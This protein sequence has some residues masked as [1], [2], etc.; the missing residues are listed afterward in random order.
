MISK[1]LIDN[2]KLY[3]EGFGDSFSDEIALD[4]DEKSENVELTMN[5]LFSK[6]L[7]IQ[8]SDTELFLSRVP[9]LVGSETSAAG[10]MRALRERTS[11]EKQK[12]V[13]DPEQSANIVR[14]RYVES[15][16]ESD[17]EIEKE[18]ETRVKN[19]T[20]QKS[21]LSYPQ[22]NDEMYDVFSF[23]EKN[24]GKLDSQQKKSLRTWKKNYSK[25]QIIEALK[26]SKD[27]K[28]DNIYGYAATIL[29]GGL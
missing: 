7:L 6:G 10:R 8:I 19:H 23:C 18:S 12:L 21:N 24:I 3:F 13:T 2:G 28:A 14:D 20:E 11:Q 27:Y 5:Y 1:S 9:A 16:L 25:S 4:I 26:L 15:E 22:N 29:A 17:I